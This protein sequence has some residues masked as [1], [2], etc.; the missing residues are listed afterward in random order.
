MEADLKVSHEGLNPSDIVAVETFFSNDT[1]FPS[2]SKKVRE[3]MR[4]PHCPYSGASYISLKTHLSKEHK[5]I[6]EN[7]LLCNKCDYLAGNDDDLKSHHNKKHKLKKHQCEFCDYSTQYPSHMAT[8]IRSKHTM[9][10]PYKCPQCD[11]RTVQS[12]HLKPHFLAKHA[13][14]KPYKC[15]YGCGYETSQPGMSSHIFLFIFTKIL[16]NVC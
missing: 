7:P 8:H 13:N 16:K 6:P 14:C 11:F 1:T 5:K 15:E 3:A 4:C 2:S 10:K 12:S 9:T